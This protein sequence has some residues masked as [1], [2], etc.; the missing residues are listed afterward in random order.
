MAGAPEEMVAKAR[1]G[2][3]DDYSSLLVF[4][5][6][7]LVKDCTQLGLVEI[8]ERVA[9]GDFDATQEEADAWLNSE[10]GQQT[11]REFLGGT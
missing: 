2:Y 5:L 4:P 1:E 10:E 11:M 8:A 6:T 3:Y 9:R 7:Q